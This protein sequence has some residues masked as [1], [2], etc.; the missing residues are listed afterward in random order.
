[1]ISIYTLNQDLADVEGHLND[2]N[3]EA[4]KDAFLKLKDD[5]REVIG[6]LD[7]CSSIQK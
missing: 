7:E 1:M 6:F 2:G 3:L 5:S 4:A